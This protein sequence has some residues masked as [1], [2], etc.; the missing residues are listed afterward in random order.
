LTPLTGTKQTITEA[1]A[2]MSADGYTNIAAGVGWGLRVLSPTV[3]FTEGA[4][5]TDDDWKKVMIV[6]TDGSNDWG[7]ELSNMNDS[8]YGGYGYTSQSAARLGMSSIGDRDGV[9]DARTAA[10]C[11][12]VK[13]AGDAGNPITVY[14]ITFGSPD[15]E[16]IELMQ[17]C[18][19]D[20]EKYFH[21][22]D[23]ATLEEAFETIGSQISKVYLSK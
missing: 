11:N 16:A 6:M 4:S 13:T 19:S 5:Y 21:A 9:L 14:T 20:P 7:S 12:A 8:Y 15:D 17:D 18:A 1:L 23:S 3:P 2:N 10:A 22:P